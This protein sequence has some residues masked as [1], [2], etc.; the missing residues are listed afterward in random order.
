[1]VRRKLFIDTIFLIAGIVTAAM[2]RERQAFAAAL[3]FAVLLIGGTRWLC[4]EKGRE[5]FGIRGTDGKRQIFC[6]LFGM[7]LLFASAQSLIPMPEDQMT[8]IASLQGRVVS[9]KVEHGYVSFD[10]DTAGSCER[11]RCFYRCKE[12]QKGRRTAAKLYGRRIRCHGKLS[13]PDGPRNPGAFDYRLY[14]KGEG[15]TYTA[16]VRACEILP[17]KIPLRWRFRRSLMRARERFT[18]RFREDPAVQAFL[19]GV[20]FGD[21]S[22]LDEET[23]KEFR[24]NTTAHVL[25]V[26][27]LHVGFLYALLR[28]LMHTRKTLP[29]AFL[30]LGTVLLYGELTKWNVSTVRAV[31]LTAAVVLSFYVRRPFDLLSASA[32]AAWLI[33]VV[34]PY[35]LFQ[36]GFAMSFLAVLG[37]AFFQ[38]PLRRLVGE[39]AGFLLA[40]QM[41]MIPYSAYAFHQYNPL[42]L[43]INLPIVFLTGL[44]VPGAILLFSAESLCGVGFRLPEEAISVLCRWIPRANHL[45]HAQGAFSFP[46]R[47]FGTEL[48][49]CAVLLLLFFASEYA[50]VLLL[51]KEGKKVLLLAAMLMVLVCPL[52]VAYRNPFLDDQVVFLDVGQGDAIH[53]RSRSGDVLIDG[54]GKREQDLGKRVLRPYFLGNGCSEVDLSLFTHLHMDHCKG[55]QELAECFPVRRMG[56]PEAYRGTVRE[57]KRI[58]YTQFGDTVFS[59]GNVSVEVLWPKDVVS[60]SSSEDENERNTVYL[61]RIGTVRIMITGDLL[62]QDERAMVEYYRGSDAI[63]CDVLKVAHHGSDHSSCEQFLDA[64]Q[65]RLAVIQVGKHNRYGHPGRKTLARLRERGIKVY[66]TDRDGALGLAISGSQITVD[67][68]NRV[69]HTKNLSRTIK[70]VR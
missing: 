50:R 56:V 64:V 48:T 11:V 54:G 46:V 21:R 45:L 39:G 19:R 38:D 58:L 40:V 32:A 41:V 30:I 9:G 44:L 69:C 42:G 8:K 65:P 53:V 25:A 67:R 24:E 33:L 16:S 62:E 22:G 20:V 15:I 1:M 18:D 34:R 14:L 6:Y 10:L 17:E 36:A 28:K 13:V 59:E 49:V 51:R 55:A 57:G 26:S 23:E 29:M 68:M 52:G 66:R 4:R 61:V 43:L 12:E 27:G 2:I 47:S 3:W 63:R 31:F 7:L 5:R 60:V 37:I 35:A 70:A